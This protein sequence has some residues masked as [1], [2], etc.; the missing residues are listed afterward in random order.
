MFPFL[1]VVMGSWAYTYVKI[2]QI[3]HFICSLLYAKYTLIMCVFFNVLRLSRR[4]RRKSP[5]R[6]LVSEIASFSWCPDSHAL[7]ILAK[8][9]WHT[10]QPSDW[11]RVSGRAQGKCQV[12]QVKSL[13]RREN[14]PGCLVS[15][16]KDVTGVEFLFGP[17]L[18]FGYSSHLALQLP[19]PHLSISFWVFR[20][21]GDLLGGTS[22]SQS[23]SSSHSRHIWQTLSGDTSKDFGHSIKN[24][25]Y[26]EKE[27][28]KGCQTQPQGLKIRAGI[29]L[30]RAWQLDLGPV[31]RVSPRKQS[32]FFM[33]N[34]S[35]HWHWSLGS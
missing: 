9:I 6:N 29:V 28:G 32:R 13:L 11:K 33:W 21:I 14:E 35:S 26:W 12:S 5:L 20:G 2:H 27:L 16:Q 31:A 17:A 30:S 25:L 19:I 7:L 23:S 18:G 15:N 3:I 24:Q 8:G 10:A 22:C 34:E 4:Q 1:V